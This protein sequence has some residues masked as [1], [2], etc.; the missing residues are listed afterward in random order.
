MEKAGWGVGS[1]NCDKYAFSKRI[2]APKSLTVPAI[3]AQIRR[4]VRQA[5]LPFEELQPDHALRRFCNTTLLNS[6]VRR[7]IKELLIGHSIQLDDAYYDENNEISRKKIMLEYMK[8]VD[9]LTIGDEH[10]LKKQVI[11][12]QDQLKN[13]PKIEQLQEQLASRIIE[14][15]SIKKTIE[16][17]QKEKIRQDQCIRESENEMKAMRDFFMK[18]VNEIEERSDGNAV[19]LVNGNEINQ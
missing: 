19:W 15:D 11:E 17:M 13:V 4:L 8:A 5:G 18:F 14:Q 12:I 7:E 16:I 2:N 3:N 9:A 10:R 1:V 6:D